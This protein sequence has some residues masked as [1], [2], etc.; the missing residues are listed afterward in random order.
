[1]WLHCLA[2]HFLLKQVILKHKGTQL[3]DEGLCWSHIS[4]LMLY[5]HDVFLFSLFWSSRGVTVCVIVVLSNCCSSHYCVKNNYNN[6]FTITVNLLWGWITSSTT[7][8]TKGLF[9]ILYST[10]TPPEVVCF[11]IVCCLA[12]KAH[13]RTQDGK[14]SLTWRY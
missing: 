13:F 6:T 7:W 12:P 4:V 10:Y 14:V 2:T 8:D 11:S 5:W 9:W 3:C 1:M